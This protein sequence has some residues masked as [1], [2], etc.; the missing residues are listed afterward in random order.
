MTAAHYA[1]IFGHAAFL[2]LLADAGANVDARTNA[3]FTPLLC[4]VQEGHVE[5]CSLLLALGC[6]SNASNCLGEVCASL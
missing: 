1:A 2:R 3:S 5:V 4:A 6:D